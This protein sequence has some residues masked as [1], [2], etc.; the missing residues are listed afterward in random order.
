MDEFDRYLELIK[1]NFYEELQKEIELN[2]DISRLADGS[3]WTLLM[4]ASCH[5]ACECGE[6]LIENGADVNAKND[7]NETALMCSAGWVC[8]ENAEYLL[9]KGA[10][11]ST[12]T[13]GRGNSALDMAIKQNFNENRKSEW[14]ELFA[15]YKNQ[16][17]EKDLETFY[18]HRLPLL[19]SLK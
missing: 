5:H 10:E 6:I 16:F 12:R 2:P 4:S 15:L 18:T 11:V 9:K 7:N 13:K 19:L 1:H 3:G 17:D 14:L 8:F